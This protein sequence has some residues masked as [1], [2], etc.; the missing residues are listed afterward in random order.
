[1]A[2]LQLKLHG[3]LNGDNPFVLRNVTREEIKHGRFS[4]TRI[5]SDDNVQPGDNAGFQ[6]GRHVVR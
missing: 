1:M 6:E 5:S 4:R 2:L 3:I